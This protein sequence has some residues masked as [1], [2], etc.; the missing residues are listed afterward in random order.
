MG[1]CWTWLVG[2]VLAPASWLLLL[3]ALLVGC[4]RTPQLEGRV[5]DLA[6]VFS[7]TERERITNMLAAYEAETSHQFVVLTVP[8]LSGEPIESY[9]LRV[10]N[11]WRL[12]RKG[13]D[14]GILITLAMQEHAAR[15]ALGLGFEPYI[16]DAKAQQI[17]DES[18]VPAL[19]KGQFAEGVESGLGQL[20]VEGRKFVAPP[21]GKRGNTKSDG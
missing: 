1:T 8:T 13:V 16:S 21:D 6:H 4:N 12:G 5:T 7:V 10:A 11:A 15:I 18:M 19:R 2:R 14:N 17:M 9:S 20:M 3:A